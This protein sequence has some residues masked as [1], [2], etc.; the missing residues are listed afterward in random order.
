L[1][2]LSHVS[3]GGDGV[4]AAVTVSRFSACLLVWRLFRGCLA[5]VVV[6]LCPLVA[7]YRWLVDGCVEK[8]VLLW[9]AFY[10]WRALLCAS[11]IVSGYQIL[12]L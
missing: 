1:A 4:V 6:V 2:D 7:V 11:I 12:T 8:C 10:W 3:V 5:A 9:V